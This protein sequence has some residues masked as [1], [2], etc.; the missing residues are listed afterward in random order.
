MAAMSASTSPDSFKRLSRPR[1]VSAISTSSSS[2]S[3]FASD[4][5]PSLSAS[6]ALH[7][8]LSVLKRWTTLQRRPSKACTTCLRTA[9]SAISIVRSA[10]YPGRMT[11]SIEKDPRSVISAWRAVR[12]ALYL[13]LPG[14]EPSSSLTGEALSSAPPPAGF[15]VSS[16]AINRDRIAPRNSVMI[17]LT[18]FARE[19]C[20]SSCDDSDPRPP[21]SSWSDSLS[22][23]PF[24][25]KNNSS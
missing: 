20:A 7:W 3:A 25:G 14:P 16:S 4:I 12:M 21:S 15:A 24:T 9:C 5:G 23:E 18:K 22:D 11:P 19:S 10:K 17:G 8:S 13:L 1:M 2:A 6:S